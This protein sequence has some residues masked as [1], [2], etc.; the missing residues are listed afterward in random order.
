MTKITAGGWGGVAGF[1]SAV[2]FV[3]VATRFSPIEWPP[4]SHE[5]WPIYIMGYACGWPAG[6]MV[7]ESAG[8]P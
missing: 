2:A 3:A 6:I 5:F 8:K 4:I 7:W 1:V